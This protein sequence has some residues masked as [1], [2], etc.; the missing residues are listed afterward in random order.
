[1]KEYKRKKEKVQINTFSFSKK[2][3]TLQKKGDEII[4]KEKNI[5]ERR[6]EEKRENQECFC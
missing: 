2:M 4:E 5:F 3:G 6:K 1:M